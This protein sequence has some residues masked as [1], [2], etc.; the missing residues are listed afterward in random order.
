MPQQAERLVGLTRDSRV[1][2]LEA[3]CL[4]RPP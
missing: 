1:G 2:H 4:D 3:G